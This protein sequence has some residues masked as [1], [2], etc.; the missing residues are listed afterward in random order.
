MLS[1][2][3]ARCY[4]LPSRGTQIKRSTCAGLVCYSEN[5]RCTFVRCVCLIGSI[6][7]SFYSQAWS[8]PLY[9][10]R[11][12]PGA[13][14]LIHDESGSHIAFEAVLV[15]NPKSLHHMIVPGAAHETEDKTVRCAVMC[16]PDTC[17]VLICPLVPASLSRKSAAHRFAHSET[18]EGEYI[19]DGSPHLD[20]MEGTLDGGAEPNVRAQRE[21]RKIAVA[22][23]GSILKMFTHRPSSSIMCTGFM[24]GCDPRWPTEKSIPVDFLDERP[25]PI[26]DVYNHYVVGCSHLV[27]M[28]PCT[29]VLL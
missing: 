5:A 21:W 2:R 13:R 6:L 26:G 10:N 18:R 8:C 22:S 14:F 19:L 28:R 23:A 17:V 1:E 3:F 4:R 29:N 7:H 27:A 11:A 24:G 20:V 15:L 9:G 16:T 12:K 25:R